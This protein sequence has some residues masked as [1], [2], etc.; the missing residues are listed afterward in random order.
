MARFNFDFPHTPGGSFSVLAGTNLSVPLN[1]WTNLG[2]VTEVL[3]G[4]YQFRDPQATN[5]PQRYYRVS[6]P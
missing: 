3:S 4:Q 2:G 1:D 5:P 6:S